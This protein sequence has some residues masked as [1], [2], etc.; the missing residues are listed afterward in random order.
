MYFFSIVTVQGAMT[1]YTTCTVLIIEPNAYAKSKGPTVFA[2]AWL[3]IGEASVT[4]TFELV[5]LSGPV[6]FPSALSLIYYRV[7][8][9][10][11]LLT[12]LVGDNAK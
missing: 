12:T 7:C 6:G 10:L 11:A 5:T 9:L 3:V 8:L 1:A 2:A 4:G